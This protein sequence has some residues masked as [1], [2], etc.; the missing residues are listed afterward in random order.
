M[1]S[2]TFRPHVASKGDKDYMTDVL[3]KTDKMKPQG[4]Q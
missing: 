1:T 4:K 2:T 3:Y